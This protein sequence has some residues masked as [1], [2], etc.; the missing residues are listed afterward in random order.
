MVIRS[1]APSQLKIGRRILFLA[2]LAKYQN[3]YLTLNHKVL[4]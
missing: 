4:L 3:I 1:V 2:S